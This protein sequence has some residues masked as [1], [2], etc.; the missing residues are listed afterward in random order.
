MLALPPAL[1]SCTRTHQIW[2]HVYTTRTS[3]VPLRFAVGR[4]IGLGR[5]KCPA[6]V[7]RW[8]S[9]LNNSLSSPCSPRRASNSRPRPR[10]RQRAGLEVRAH[11]E[12][13][14]R[15][16]PAHHP[17][18]PRDAPARRRLGGGAAAPA[19]DTWDGRAVAR[20]P[21]GVNYI[22]RL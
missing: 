3:I 20:G 9:A 17:L 19:A 12:R 22:T 14:G 10:R 6:A 21:V 7:Q 8:C 1:V 2:M 5:K 16:G 13:H 11:A 4:S 15:R 18:D